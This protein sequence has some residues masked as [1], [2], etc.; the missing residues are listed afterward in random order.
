MV[1]TK[2][3]HPTANSLLAQANGVTLCYD[4]FGN[5]NHPPMLLI[6]GLGMQ[7]IA[8]DHS[9]CQALADQGFWV[10]I[11]D[12]RD[13]GLSTKIEATHNHAPLPNPSFSPKNQAISS[14][15]LTD[16]AN[17]AIGLLDH[18]D[19][20]AAH[21][22]GMSMGGMIAQT[23]AIQNPNRLLSLT[24]I[25]SSM[26]DDLLGDVSPEV[27]AT[28]TAPVPTEREMYATYSAKCEQI[29]NGEVLPFDFEAS[30]QNYLRYYDRCF[31]PAGG[32]RH[33]AAILASGSR[34]EALKNVT[35]P[36]L[37]IH[38]DADPLVLVNAG[39]STAQTI[40]NAKLHIIKG[41]GHNLH[42]S[43]QSDIIGLIS[44]HA[45][46]AESQHKE[47]MTANESRT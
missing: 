40:P 14:Y 46:Q 45:H 3:S 8:W 33:M 43:C 24:S 37:V 32:E 2:N 10:I 17:D 18:L 35:V 23:I 7:M 4:T 47:V 20:V 44:H 26:G 6:R 19:I 12:N 27:M 31:Y 25:M 5:R 1:L 16:M 11:Y 39:I 15:N 22:V 13:V 21:V 34:V 41:M 38:G 36:T 29:Y 42:P 30:R 28:L 9:F